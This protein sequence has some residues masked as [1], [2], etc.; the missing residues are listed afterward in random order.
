MRRRRFQVVEVTH[1]F[2]VMDT[3][4]RTIW[5]RTYMTSGWA[6]RRAI[7]LNESHDKQKES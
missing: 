7:R 5:T 3:K 6:A 4:D 1:G 2:A